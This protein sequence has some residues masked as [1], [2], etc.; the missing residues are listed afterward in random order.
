M[1]DGDGDGAREGGLAADFAAGTSIVIAPTP[2]AMPATPTATAVRFAADAGTRPAAST[3][4][5]PTF[6]LND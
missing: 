4:R 6:W 5:R 1:T 3:A 2:T